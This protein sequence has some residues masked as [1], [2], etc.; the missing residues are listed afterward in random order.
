MGFDQAQNIREYKFDGVVEGEATRH[1]VVSADLVLF[2]KHHVGI[3]EGPSLC[4]RKLSADLERLQQLHHQLT[5][6][7]LLAYVSA[8]ASTVRRKNLPRRWRGPRKTATMTR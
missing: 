6:D 8:R 7:D 5:N 1:F 3:Q 4:L 2:V